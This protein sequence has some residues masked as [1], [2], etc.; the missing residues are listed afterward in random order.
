MGDA[1]EV[2]GQRHVLAHGERRDEVEE[3]EDEAQVP[4]PVQGTLAIVEGREVAFP[5]EHPT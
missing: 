1:I 2:E 3:L 4:T 5:P